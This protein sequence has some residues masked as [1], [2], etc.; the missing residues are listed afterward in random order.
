M[1]TAQVLKVTHDVDNKV[2]D[3]EEKVIGIDHR[4]IEVADGTQ[5]VF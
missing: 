4:M 3:V 1:A 2:V 5:D